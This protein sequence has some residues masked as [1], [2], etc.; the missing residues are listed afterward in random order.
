MRTVKRGRVTFLEGRGNRSAKDW[1]I[2][3]AGTVVRFKAVCLPSLSLLR[4]VMS[5]IRLCLKT[6]NHLFIVLPFVSSLC[7]TL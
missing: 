1:D 3:V 4:Y 5:W 2:L 6:L 7:L